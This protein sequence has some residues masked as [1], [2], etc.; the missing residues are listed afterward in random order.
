MQWIEIQGDD[1]AKCELCGV[2]F[3]YTQEI[4]HKFSC[5]K[6]DPEKLNDTKT[7]FCA[8][9]ITMLIMM[10]FVG[11]VFSVVTGLD[12]SDLNEMVF[13]SIMLIAFI[14]TS[15]VS[16]YGCYRTCTYKIIKTI[17][18]PLE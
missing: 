10:F 12:T 13:F 6:V 15:A 18:N 8:L 5:S 9:L 16:V 3:N 4:T 1:K 17:L 2:S 7:G 11:I 14:A